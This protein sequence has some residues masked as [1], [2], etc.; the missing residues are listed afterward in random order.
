MSIVSQNQK[1]HHREQK[2]NKERSIYSV[3]NR[4]SPSKA[5]ERTNW[6]KCQKKSQTQAVGGWVLM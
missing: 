4:S 2:M 6:H 1:V 5:W 3:H